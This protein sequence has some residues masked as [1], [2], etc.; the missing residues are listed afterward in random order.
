MEYYHKA[1]GA[2]IYDLEQPL[3]VNQP[4]K[5]EIRA[6]GEDTGSILLI[7]ELCTRTRLSDKARTDI[8]VMKDITIY[9][10]VS[11]QSRVDT[12]M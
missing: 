3:L 2:E 4:K 1:Y 10:G 9:I 8:R 7:P 12:L 11:P 6:R 5:R